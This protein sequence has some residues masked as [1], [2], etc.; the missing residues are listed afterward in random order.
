MDHPV[1]GAYNTA[2]QD[3]IRGQHLRLA[4]GTIVG[5]KDVDIDF[6]HNPDHTWNF[7]VMVDGQVWTVLDNYG[8][9]WVF[10]TLQERIGSQHA[11][12]G[13]QEATGLLAFVTPSKWEKPGAQ[14]TYGLCFTDLNAA[15]KTDE[16]QEHPRVVPAQC[17]SPK[18]LEELRRQ[19]RPWKLVADPNVLLMMI[20]HD[21]CWDDVLKSMEVHLQLSN[22]TIVLDRYGYEVRPRRSTAYSAASRKKVEVE[23]LVKP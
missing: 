12:L 2:T 16:G 14:T 21:A 22:K 10:G 11:L 19:K 1:Y 3:E 8:N 20:E 7:R 18:A 6:Q 23:P 5:W 17:R 13:I 9:D 15:L 4:T